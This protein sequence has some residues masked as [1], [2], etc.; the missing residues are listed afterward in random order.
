METKQQIETIAT[1]ANQIPLDDVYD[2]ITEYRQAQAIAPT[3]IRLAFGRRSAPPEGTMTWPM[4]SSRS[5]P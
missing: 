5:A 4:R 2:L 3:F 1:L